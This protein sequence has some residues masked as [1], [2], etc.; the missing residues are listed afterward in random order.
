MN[1]DEMLRA[2]ARGLAEV[3][4]VPFERVEHLL[5]ELPRD[6]RSSRALLAFTELMQGNL[7]SL[8]ARVAGLRGSWQ[9]TRPTREQLA[10]SEFWWV[11]TADRPPT[12]VLVT[13]REPNGTPSRGFAVWLH[14]ERA[15]WRL[16]DPRFHDAEWCPCVAPEQ[17]P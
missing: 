16:D 5:N 14:M 7:D 1:D 11:R 17:R 13:S 12:V 8:A 6:E 9:S 2:A 10:E 15:P 4:G 3:L